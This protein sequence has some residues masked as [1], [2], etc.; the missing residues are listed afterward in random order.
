MRVPDEV[1]KCVAYVGLPVVNAAGQ[2]AMRPG[3]TAFFVSIP[4]A[5]AGRNF[6]YLV[7]AKHVAAAVQGCDFFVRVTTTDDASFTGA[8]PGRRRPRRWGT[9]HVRARAYDR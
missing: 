9:G 5:V 8:V 1:R 4:S 2:R 3:G 7:T 6:I